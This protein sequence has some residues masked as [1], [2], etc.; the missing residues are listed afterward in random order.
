[1]QDLVNLEGAEEPD[2]NEPCSNKKSRGRTEAI[3]QC[4]GYRC[5]GRVDNEGRWEDLKGRPL[6]VQKI[7]RWLW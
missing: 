2:S 6:K 5:M 1:M 3:V 7:V 4:D